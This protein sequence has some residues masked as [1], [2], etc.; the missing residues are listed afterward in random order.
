MSFLSNN[1]NS[2]SWFEVI[3]KNLSLLKTS[4][5]YDKKSVKWKRTNRFIEVL[6]QNARFRDNS[7]VEKKHSDQI[8]NK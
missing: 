6:F 7:R 3:I 5:S 1:N 2:I 8:W 4:V